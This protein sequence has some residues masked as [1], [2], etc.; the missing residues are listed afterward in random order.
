MDVIIMVVYNPNSYL[1]KIR[2]LDAIIR[3]KEEECF[4][5]QRRFDILAEHSP[6]L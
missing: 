4:K 3:E 5:L 2:E 6:Y 1:D